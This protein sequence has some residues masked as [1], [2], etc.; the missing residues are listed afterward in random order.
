MT[1]LQIHDQTLDGQRD[2]APTE[3][4]FD[5]L[6]ETVTVRELIRARV[7]QEADDHNRRV[8][9]ANAGAQPY[10]GLVTPADAERELNGPKHGRLLAKEVDWR[11]QFDAAIDAFERNGFLI[12]V[13]DE[14]LTDLDAAITLGPSTD[15]AFVRLTMLVGG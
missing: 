2:A 14:Q 1:T 3:L 11:K 10:G 9:E 5:G 8:R 15:V 7:Y 12:L 6:A 4:T 13:D